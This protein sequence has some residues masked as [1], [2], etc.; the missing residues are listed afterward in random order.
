MMNHIFPAVTG[1]TGIGKT[2]VAFE[3]AKRING[4]I[5]NADSQSV[6]KYFNIGTSK[7]PR[8][9]R[10]VIAHHLVGFRDPREQFSVGDFVSTAV[11]EAGKILKRGKTPVISGGS[12]LYVSSLAEGISMLPAS[13]DIRRKLENTELAKLLEELRKVDRRTYEKIDRRNPRRIIRALEIYRI[14]GEPPSRA[15]KKNFIKG[16]N[17]KIF[18]LEM[19][20]DELYGKIDERVEF[21]IRKG[22][23]REARSILKRGVPPTAPPFS[24][25]GYR[26]VLEFIRCCTTLAETVEKIKMRTHN[27]ARKQL[28]WWRGKKVVRIG[29]SGKSPV[30]VASEI[31]EILHNEQNKAVHEI[32]M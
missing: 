5:I 4:E 16:L 17:L 11:R 13:K 9:L 1:P 25:I 6:Y 18:F 20:R 30:A 29:V 2:Q 22:L 28:I 3:L 32:G 31:A 19:P 10:Q 27:L 15:L 26:E 23:V 21:M 14:T 8:N 24:S 12:G 7:P